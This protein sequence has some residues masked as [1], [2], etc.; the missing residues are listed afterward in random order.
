MIK[1]H[2]TWTAIR[3][4][5]PH[6]MKITVLLE[7]VQGKGTTD[8]VVAGSRHYITSKRAQCRV[9]K[10][11]DLPKDRNDLRTQV[12]RDP[13]SGVNA[14][15]FFTLNFPSMSRSA[16]ETDPNAYI[17]TTSH[18][19]VSRQ[20]TIEGAK[21]VEIKGRSII[22]PECVIEGERALIK[23]GRY[24]YLDFGTVIRPAPNPGTTGETELSYIPVMIGS[25]TYI[26]S[27]C[28]IEAASIGS[29][30][31]IGHNVTMG[32]RVI[33][34]DCCV[35]ADNTVISD[36]TVLPPFTRMSSSVDGA[37]SSISSA[38]QWTYPYYQELP[39]STATLM[40]ERSMDLYQEF[41]SVRI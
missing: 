24:V 34:K 10:V 12:T 23:I 1:R 9:G 35:I 40:Q 26:G 14:N 17:K 30:C 20:A 32:K 28:H 7:V 21:Q 15:V 31:Y 36:D 33:V 13:T 37:S 22:Q 8:T 27:K 25:H 29:Q 41:S 19:Y 38:A 11:P 2:G 5:A 18:S 4:D 39:A 6:F 16:D 3:D